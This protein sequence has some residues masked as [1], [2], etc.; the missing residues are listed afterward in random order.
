MRFKTPHMIR[1]ELLSDGSIPAFQQ[2]ITLAGSLYL[3]ISAVCSLI[4]ICGTACLDKP[5]IFKDH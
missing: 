1:T 5:D 3:L 2:L 4:N